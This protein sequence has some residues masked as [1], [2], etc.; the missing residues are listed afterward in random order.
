MVN[1]DEDRFNH[2]GVEDILNQPLQLLGK[3]PKGSNLDF[4]EVSRETRF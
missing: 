3:W 1:D 2:I 4:L